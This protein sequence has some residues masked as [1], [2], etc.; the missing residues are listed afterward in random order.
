VTANNIAGG[1]IGIA[2][3]QYDTL[4]GTSHWSG[5]TITNTVS[6]GIFVSGD[7][8]S[9]LESFVIANNTITKTTGV[10]TNLHPTSGTYTL[11]ANSFS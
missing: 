10:Y 9:N 11:A 8:T 2:W 1:D 3:F 4:P 6:A 5:N 7:T